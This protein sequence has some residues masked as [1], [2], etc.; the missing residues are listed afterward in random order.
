MWV[1]ESRETP[2]DGWSVPTLLIDATLDIELVRPFWPRVEHK[3]A[4]DVATPYQTIRQATGR[5]F[6]KSA[7]LAGNYKPGKTD[8]N[9]RKRR[10]LGAVIL[11]E[12]RKAGAKTLVVGNKSIIDAL[13]LP[14]DL[15]EAAWFNAIA[16]HDEWRDARLII[17]VGR[18][19]P[20]PKDIEAK[21]GALSGAAPVVLDGWY[22]RTDAYR[23]KW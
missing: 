2:A 22:Q 19:M 23:L 5:S 13:A 6:S 21:A 7:L 18:P 15:V 9:A 11:R 1:I 4:F 10:N 3:G 17:I 12:A 8:Y 14:S 20:S 16:G